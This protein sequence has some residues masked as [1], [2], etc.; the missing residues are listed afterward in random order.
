MLQQKVLSLLEISEMTGGVLKGDPNKKVIRI[1]DLSHNSVD[2]ISPL[3][4]KKFVS[5][6]KP[7]MTLLSKPGWIPED[8]MGV[9]VDDPRLALVSLLDFFDNHIKE[10][11]MIHVTA[12][13]SPSASIGEN[14]HIG[15]NCVISDNVVIGANCVLVG[16][17]WIGNGVTVGDATRIE[18]GAVL[19]ESAVIGRN[20]IIHSNAVI[21]S[22]GFGFIPDKKVG[23][24]RIPQ[25]GKVI[26]QDSVEIGTCVCVDRATFGETLV[27]SGTKLDA[28]VKVG[29]NC[30]IGKFCI[31]V[32]QSGI[33]GSSTIGDG[34]VL[35]AQSGVAN[36]AS[37]GNGVTVAA[38]GG[39]VNSV[40]DGATVSGFP[41]QEHRKE[42][43]QM[44][45]I[46]QLPELLST[47]KELK[48]RVAELEEAY[49]KK[50]NA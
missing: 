4:E 15:P 41:A 18:P 9:E 40:P 45:A 39:I 50:P 27:S 44:L 14:V 23:L 17:I 26:I 20:C 6:L 7:D 32:S 42:L 36:H 3:W 19:H 31:V 49:E 21:G 24:L 28:L 43:K 25:I 2:T 12:V 10:T 5:E 30:Q 33:A 46:K 47:I 8:C 37:V 38:R 34:V 11:P 22:D 1:S 29:H 16:N 13:I 48:H 35:A